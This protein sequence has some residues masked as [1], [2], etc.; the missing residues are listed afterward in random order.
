MRR[1]VSMGFGMRE[2]AIPGRA[3]TSV[4]GH[5]PFSRRS[6]AISARAPAL[7]S[8]SKPR[9]PCCGDGTQ[10]QQQ[11]GGGERVGRRVVADRAFDAERREPVV[12][13]AT[14]VAIRVRHQRPGERSE[15]EPRPIVG[16]ESRAGERDA[17]H[18]AIEIGV[19]AHARSIARPT[20]GTRRARRAPA[21]PPP[22][23]HGRSR[24]RRCWRHRPTGRP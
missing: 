13:A 16:R 19:K 6:P 7:T 8:A 24:G 1:S 20:R 14:A 12:E 5:A 9:V 23:R 15:I 2:P 10:P 4:R 21:F 22:A 18:R 17:Q 11:L 3:G